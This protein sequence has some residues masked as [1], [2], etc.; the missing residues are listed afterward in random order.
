MSSSFILKVWRD[1]AKKRNKILFKKRVS[2]DKGSS[3]QSTDKVLKRELSYIEKIKHVVAWCESKNIEV[4][5]SKEGSYYSETQKIHINQRLKP[6]TQ[7][8]VLLHECGHHLIG[9]KERHERYGMGYTVEDASIKRSLIHRIDVLDE[10]LEAWHR[11]RKL[12]GRLCISID[13]KQFDRV[14]AKMVKTYVRW[15]IS[16]KTSTE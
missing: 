7:L 12:A 1:Q 6:E 8:Y 3:S 5:F 15:T 11:G 2:G 16:T 13:K 10:E 9:Y 4:I 14:R